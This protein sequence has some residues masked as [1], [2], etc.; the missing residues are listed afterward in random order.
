VACDS[1]HRQKV[2]SSSEKSPRVS[3]IIVNWNGK[4]HLE[5]CL[6]SLAGQTYRDF[7]VILVDNG[8]TDSSAA[9]VRERYPW[10]RLVPL[11]ENT[12]FAGGNNRGFACASG[13]YIVTLNNDTRAEPD[14]L[15]MLVSVAD[16]HQR[17]GMVGCRTCV[18]GKRDII[19]TLGGRV[20]CDGM[21]RGAF[22]FAG[23][24]SLGLKPVEE[25]LYPSA[26][27]ALY[28]RAMIDET[29][30]FDEDFFAYCED[31]DLGLRGRLAGWDAVLATDAVVHHKYSGT[32]GVL[33]PLKVF[34][35]ERNHYWVALKTFPLHL[36]LLVPVFTV[37]RYG[38]QL[39]AVLGR[40]GTGGE[41]MTGGSGREIARALLHG[42]WSA[43]FGIPGMLG[44]R[45]EIMKTRK[46]TTREMSLLLRRYRLSFRELLDRGCD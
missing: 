26:C 37:V 39:L 3:V 42:A 34:L 21:S 18:F 27:A 25:A 40:E 22:R 9:F 29:G 43:L 33:S 36:L 7:E 20:C 1:A 12:G 32:V 30:F 6:E 19:D 13:E 23:F 38:E 24:S 8:S 31:T 17:A 11:A 41:F 4:E 46:I 2:E 16:T 14:W 28:R 45:R 5:S 10:V 15:E 35:V 44:K